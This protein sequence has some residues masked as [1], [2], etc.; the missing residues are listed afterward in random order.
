MRAV[1]EDV[2]K[3]EKVITL[4]ITNAVKSIMYAFIIIFGENLKNQEMFYFS[5]QVKNLLDQYDTNGEKVL[6][7]PQFCVSFLFPDFQ[8]VNRKIFSYFFLH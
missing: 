7:F 2:D 3:N 5:F 6:H 1:N 8:N 4:N